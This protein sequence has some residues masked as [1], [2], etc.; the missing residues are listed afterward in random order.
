MFMSFTS[1]AS[2]EKHYSIY[3][4][5]KYIRIPSSCVLYASSGLN[6][7]TINFGCT[8]GDAPPTE[9]ISLYLRE[10]AALKFLPNVMERNS[11]Y[12]E[13][14]GNTKQSIFTYKR[15]A[16]EI[17]WYGHEVCDDRMCILVNSKN[18]EFIKSIIDQINQ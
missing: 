3:A 18:K 13:H 14:V 4:L 5:D 6:E 17:D 8:V 16:A 9:G 1:A 15:D 12:I 7:K 10:K 11:F 2:D